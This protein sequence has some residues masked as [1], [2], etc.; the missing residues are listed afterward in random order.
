KRWQRSGR[1]SADEL[2]K[3]GH[4]KDSLS[5]LALL[6]GLLCWTGHADAGDAVDVAASLAANDPTAADT[7][8]N[9]VQRK[10]EE[11][12]V[13][14]IELRNA[15]RPIYELTPKEA[16]VLQ[17]WAASHPTSY[18]AHLAEGIYFKRRGFAARGD[19]FISETSPSALEEMRR[20][21]VPA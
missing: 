6:A 11:G 16:E 17:A 4:V 19:K 3:G 9:G 1:R 21:L 20:N 13:T 15:F 18:A 14:E 7:Y 2:G 12:A 8:L 5:L 10:F